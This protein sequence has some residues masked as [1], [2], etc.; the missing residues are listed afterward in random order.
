MLTFSLHYSRK[1]Q[2][3]DVAVYF[4]FKAMYDACLFLAELA[5][6]VPL[7]ICDIPENVNIALQ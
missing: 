3:Q 4:P 5:S 2:P 6:R 1:Y 7:S